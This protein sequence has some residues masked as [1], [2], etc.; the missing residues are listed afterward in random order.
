MLNIYH[1]HTAPKTL[2]RHKITRNAD[3]IHD[4]IPTEMMTYP[5]ALEYIESLNT[6]GDTGWR[7][8]TVSEMQSLLAEA[9]SPG[10]QIHHRLPITDIYWTSETGEVSGVQVVIPFDDGGAEGHDLEGFFEWADI[11]DLTDI[12]VIPESDKAY[13]Y[14][15]RGKLEP[16]TPVSQRY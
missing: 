11:D 1:Y 6:N 15:V 2:L 12:E 9:I 10:T 3:N 7:L 16:F 5:E 4:K 14:P 13:A 8:P